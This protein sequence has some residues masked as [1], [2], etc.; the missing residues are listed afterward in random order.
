MVVHNERRQLLGAGDDRGKTRLKSE[1]DTKLG[2]FSDDG[3]RAYLINDSELSHRECH[4]SEGPRETSKGGQALKPLKGRADTQIVGSCE[5]IV[6]PKCGITADNTRSSRLWSW[7]EDKFGRLAVDVGGSEAPRSNCSIRDKG[8]PGRERDG[9]G[10]SEFGSDGEA[11]KADSEAVSVD[12]PRRRL[13]ED[14]GVD[15]GGVG[16]RH[17]NVRRLGG[18]GGHGSLRSSRGDVQLQIGFKRSLPST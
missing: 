16:S 11:G 6:G 8:G 12:V 1:H 14:A 15:R 2:S 9:L 5:G 3:Q 17:E 7:N 4:L 13:E 18:L 10:T